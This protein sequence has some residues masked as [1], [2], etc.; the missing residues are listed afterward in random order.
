[1]LLF[2]RS[3]VYTGQKAFWSETSGQALEALGTTPEGLSSE[4]AGRRLKKYGLNSLRPKKRSDP[5]TLL[6]GQFKSPIIIL[7]LFAAFLSIYLGDKADSLIIL[8]IVFLSGALGF[9]QEYSA[10]NAV[11]KLLEMVRVKAQVLRDGREEDVP[12]EEIVPGDVLVLNAGDGIP[13]DCLILES[14]DLFVDEAALTGETYPVEKTVKVLP[15]ETQLS[16]RLNSLFMGTHVVSGTAK[17]VVIKTGLETEFGHISEQLRFKPPTP[18]FER[19]VRASA[20]YCWK[21]PPS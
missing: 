11:E 10:A 20:I 3:I 5:L 14:R 15:P 13:G 7:L 21:S 18:E 2:I 17:A 9:W 16:K 19:G 12:F 1:V 6:I 8:V 4:E